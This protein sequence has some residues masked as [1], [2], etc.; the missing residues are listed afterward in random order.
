LCWCNHATIHGDV[1]S[2]DLGLDHTFF[3]CCRGV[4]IA[5]V[6]AVDNPAVKK[7]YASINKA[8]KENRLYGEMQEVS[9]WARSFSNNRRFTSCA[10][11]N[12]ASF[13]CPNSLSMITHHP[14]LCKLAQEYV[15]RHVA[16]VEEVT[17]D[18]DMRRAW[19]DPSFV[20]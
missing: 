17:W 5:G 16:Y 11:C 15:H 13:M 6:Y 14:C 7:K 20:N 19:H 8:L 18:V 2:R 9:T 12:L 10:P 1:L 4:G 3:C